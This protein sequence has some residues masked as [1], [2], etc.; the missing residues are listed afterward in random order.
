[1]NRFVPVKELVS[2]RRVVEAVESVPEIV[3]GEVPIV[4]KEEQEVEPEQETVVVATD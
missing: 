1:M 2:E 4:M 3:I